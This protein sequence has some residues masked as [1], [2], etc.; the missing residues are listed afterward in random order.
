MANGNEP[1]PPAPLNGAGASDPAE[2]ETLRG[3]YGPPDGHGIYR[4]VG[5]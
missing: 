2:E 4:R 5:T 3:L 1:E